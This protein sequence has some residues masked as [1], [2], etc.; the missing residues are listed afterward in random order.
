MADQV[1]APLV[2]DLPKLD[3]H[4]KG[5]IVKD[6]QLKHI[7]VHEKVVLPTAED[8]K[9]EKV[10]ESLLQGVETFSADHLKP[11]KTREPASAT[12]VMQVELAHSTSLKEVEKFDKNALKNVDTVEKNPLPD[13]DAIKQ[14]V[15]HIAF[16][17]GI[18]SFDKDKLTPTTPVEKN[19]LPTKEVIEMEKTAE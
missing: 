10:H 8:L 7:E 3:E 16:V 2:K 5:E 6:V 1:E 15:E 11:T 18:E 19:T 13:Q 9:Q 14:E 17:T 12:E 4:I